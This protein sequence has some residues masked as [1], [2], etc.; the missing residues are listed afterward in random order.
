MKTFDRL[1]G[2]T[3]AGSAPHEIGLILD[4]AKAFARRIAAPQRPKRRATRTLCAAW[5]ASTISAAP[6][7]R[8][9]GRRDPIE[10]DDAT[11]RPMHGGDRAETDGRR[12]RLLDRFEQCRSPVAVARP[13]DGHDP[14]PLFGGTGE[15]FEHRR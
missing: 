10:I 15:P 7:A 5:A 1:I 14:E 6:R 8:K 4:A 2:A 3:V 9:A 11:I 13:L 12:A